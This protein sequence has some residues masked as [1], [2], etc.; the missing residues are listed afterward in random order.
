MKKIAVLLSNKGTGSNL[1]AILDAI[2]K[3]E[4]KN[5]QVVV[6]VS[7]QEDAYGLVRARSWKIAT[8]VLDLK[9]FLRKGKSRGEYDE[10]LGKLLKEKYK[11]DLVVLAGWMLILSKNFIK[12]FPNR[13]I[14]LHPGLLPDGAA[15]YIKLPSGIKIKAIRGLVTDEAVQFAIHQK[16]PF[17]GS[18]VHFITEKV[19]QG[20]IILRSEVEILPDDTVES[21]YERMKKEEHKILPK[22]IDLFCKDRL[23]VRNGKVIVKDAGTSSA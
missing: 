22:A 19:D 5:G 2:D 8:E 10:T 21:L 4:I 9:D 3:G 18:T 23:K 7:D 13:T 11:A 15:K 12:Y 17:T 16:Y 14:N 1:Q 6:V 20:P